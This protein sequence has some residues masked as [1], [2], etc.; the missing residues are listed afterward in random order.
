MRIKIEEPEKYIYKCQYKVV[1]SDLNYGNHLSNEK[2]L[3]IAHECRMR[4]LASKSWTEMDLAGTSLIQ[5]DA[6]VVYYSEGFYGDE[7][8]IELGI[9]DVAR[10]SF[11]LVFKMHNST[12]DK[13][14][15]LVKTGM[16][17]YDY[18]LKKVNPVPEELKAL[19]D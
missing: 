12:T 9:L 14:L 3:A 2:L 15:A 17:C 4:F 1:V 10:V 16:V 8:Q 11:D 5:G 7:I 18:D 6:A 13:P 19:I